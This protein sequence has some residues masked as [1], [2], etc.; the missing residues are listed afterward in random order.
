MFAW[1]RRFV[2]PISRHSSSAKF[3]TA[4]YWQ[5]LLPVV[6]STSIY[7]LT[8]SRWHLT[9]TDI[10]TI[11]PYQS[12][13]RHASAHMDQHVFSLNIGKITQGQLINPEGNLAGDAGEYKLVLTWTSAAASTARFD[14]VVIPVKKDGDTLCDKLDYVDYN[15]NG[16]ILFHHLYYFTFYVQMLVEQSLE[17]DSM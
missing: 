12:T 6:G 1:Y 5:L 16:N 4:N 13:W 10:G 9:T 11:N 2:K 3:D 17:L 8:A 7:W 15:S 14:L